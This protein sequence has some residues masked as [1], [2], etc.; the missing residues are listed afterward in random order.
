MEGSNLPEDVYL[1][2]G[3]KRVFAAAP[4]WSGWNRSEKDEPAAL[5]ALFEYAPR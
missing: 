1:E 4:N 3:K 2:M 5:Q